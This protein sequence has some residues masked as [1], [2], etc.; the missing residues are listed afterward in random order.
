MQ[1]RWIFLEER[2]IGPQ[3]PF[4]RPGYLKVL[5]GGQVRVIRN[6]LAMCWG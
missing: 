6:K 1:P 5:A 3:S 2:A 4:A